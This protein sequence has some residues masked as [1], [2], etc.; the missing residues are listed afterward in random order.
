MNEIVEFLTAQLDAEWQLTVA[1]QGRYADG[2]PWGPSWTYDRDHFRVVINGQGAFA[3]KDTRD[4]DGEHIAYWDPARVLAD[5]AAKR[6]LLALWQK[7]DSG[8]YSP[9]A[10]QLADELLEQLLAPYGKRAV[11]TREAGWRIDG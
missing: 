7:V 6:N 8:V 10:N 5:V 4:V 3:A 1:A 11:W 9:D 2:S